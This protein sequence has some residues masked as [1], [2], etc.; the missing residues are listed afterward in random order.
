[1]IDKH[2]CGCRANDREWLTM[3][4]AHRL[5]HD[6]RHLR[7]AKEKA[8]AELV[9]RYSLGAPETGVVE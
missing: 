8:C 9:G 4:P 5:E 3:C 6:E 2:P 1:M 7:A